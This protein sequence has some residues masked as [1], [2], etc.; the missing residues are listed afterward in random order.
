MEDVIASFCG[1]GQTVNLPLD[2]SS[3]SSQCIPESS[4]VDLSSNSVPCE[5]DD[6]KISHKL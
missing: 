4:F 6:R 2:L 3:K 1:S 5:N